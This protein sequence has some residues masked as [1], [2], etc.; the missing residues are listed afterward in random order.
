MPAYEQ[1]RP[2][3]PGQYAIGIRAVHV[4]Q[5]GDIVVEP[6]PRP[7]PEIMEETRLV[8]DSVR[9]VA[10]DREGDQA[11]VLG[12]FLGNEMFYHNRI[13]SLLRFG[14]QLKIASGKEVM[15][16][17]STRDSVI[18]VV[19]TSG[20][21][22]RTIALPI[23]G[24]RLV[25]RDIPAISAVGALAEFAKAIPRPDSMPLFSNLLRGTDD[26]LWVQAFQAPSDR[27]QEWLAFDE[28]GELAA[29]LTMTAD[30]QLFA[31]GSDYALV[32]TTDDYGVQT[33]Q[34][35]RLRTSRD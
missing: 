23:E 18:R 4:S 26:R 24:R 29:T 35:H 7:R 33:V 8:Q 31:V 10:F 5:Y 22:V 28:R 2:Q 15:F 14:E 27:W 34:M 21:I 12:P 16:V 30:K 9:L 3:F 25:P 32:L 1:L 13:G 20:R 17:A 11:H 6:F 19:A